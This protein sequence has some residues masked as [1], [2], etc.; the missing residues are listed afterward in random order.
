MEIQNV[1]SNSIKGKYN[2]R[3]YPVEEKTFA[4][5]VRDRWR[6]NTERFS[7][8]YTPLFEEKLDG[9]KFARWSPPGLPYVGDPSWTIE[10]L[11]DGLLADPGFGFPLTVFHPASV[12]FDMN[13]TAYLSRI[14]S[15]QRT[16]SSQLY[17]GYNAQRFQLWGSTTPDVTSDFA[18]WFFLGD[19]E[20]TK[21]SGLPLGQLSDED[22]AFGDAGEDFMIQE[23]SNIPVRYIRLVVLSAFG[24]GG[25]GGQFYEME[26]FGKIIE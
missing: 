7:G 26:F 12:T 19:F 1:Y 14:K 24:G 10:R 18:T 20:Y 11:W 21:P 17:A 8:S 22:I 13:Q 15:F 5:T 6:N 4:V 25:S 3:G 16:S 2:L 9:S 23:N